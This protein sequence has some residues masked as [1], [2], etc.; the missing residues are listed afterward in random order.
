MLKMCLKSYGT[1]INPDHIL[2]FMIADAV[3]DGDSELP[4]R[5]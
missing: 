2:E 5:K 4:L 3:R 1:K